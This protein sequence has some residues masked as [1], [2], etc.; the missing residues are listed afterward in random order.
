ML[1]DWV[2]IR[3]LAREIEQRLRGAR[4]DDAGLL[5]DGRIAIAFRQRGARSLLAVD[6]FASPPLVTLE[7]GEL[8]VG[9]EPG[10]VRALARSLRGMTLREVTARR[11]DRLLRLSFA[12]RSRFGVGDEFELYLEFVPR[13]GNVVLVKDATVVAAR[14]EFAFA[15]NPRRAVQAGAPYSLPPLPAQERVLG[16]ADDERLCEPLFVYRRS[17]ELLQAYVVPLEGFEDA[18]LF[19]EPSLLELFAELRVQQSLRSGNER[20]EARRRAVIQTACRARAQ[21]P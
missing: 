13:F 5:P 12:S 18:D 20:V 11:N 10:F 17:R 6:L 1:T 15:E 9:I 4:V 8:G 3:R 21:T 14:K 19:R 16:P 2:L 7:E